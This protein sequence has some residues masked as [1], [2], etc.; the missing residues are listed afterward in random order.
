MKTHH[1]FILLAI[2]VITVFS[3]C[4]KREDVGPYQEGTLTYNLT[5]FTQLRMGSAFKINVQQ[6]NIFSISVRGDRRNLDDLNVRVENGVLRADYFLPSRNRQYTT[7]FTII[8]PVLDGV[9]FSGAVV[10]NVAGFEGS[11]F[12]SIRLSGASIGTFSLKAKQCEINLSGASKLNMTGNS[13][14]I[15]ADISGASILESFNF[16]TEEAQVKLSGASNA[17]LSVSK[18]LSAEASGASHLRYIGNPT[19]VNSNVSGA[20]SVSKE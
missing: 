17:L 14:K 18:I 10:S 19:T 2:F 6:G 15:M 20:S 1:L 11:N 13:Q 7:E 12:T 8:M 4:Q 16:P 3:S 5:N 9:D